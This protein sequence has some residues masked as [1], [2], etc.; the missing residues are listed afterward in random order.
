MRESTK[1]PD[2]LVIAVLVS[3]GEEVIDGTALYPAIPSITTAGYHG[4][5]GLLVG[6]SPK[7]LVSLIIGFPAAII[8]QSRRGCSY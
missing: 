7:K 1:Q 6:E 2:S 5:L 3:L 4:Q 8:M